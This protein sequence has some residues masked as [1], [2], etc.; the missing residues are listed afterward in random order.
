MD[1][2]Y[3]TITG[4]QYKLGDEFFEKGMEVMLEKEP[5]NKVDKEAIMVKL[6]GLGTVGYVANSVNTVLGDCWSAGRMYDKIGD[7]AAGIVRFVLDRGVV[8]ELAAEAPDDFSDGAADNFE[9][10][11]GG[12]AGADDED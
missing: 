5:D 8:C 6:P 1:K 12:S 4:L 7:T 9:E 2:I 10:P 3:F 11:K